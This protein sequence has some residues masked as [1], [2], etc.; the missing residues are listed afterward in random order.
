M[1]NDVMDSNSVPDSSV[2]FNSTSFIDAL[3]HNQIAYFKIHNKYISFLKESAE[4]NRACYDD[5]L[6]LKKN[7]NNN[8]RKEDVG[9]KVLVDALTGVHSD[10]KD[11]FIF[12]KAQCYY[13]DGEKY[14]L[15]GDERS[16]K[17]FKKRCLEEFKKLKNPQL[18]EKF[19][20]EMGEYLPR[21]YK[22]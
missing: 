8:S 1:I 15:F 17:Y 19:K 4:I 3:R 13:V 10:A 14:R 18:I 9:I 6:L 7:I 20:E 12:V 16:H 5:M 2:A 22:Q 11:E 21:K